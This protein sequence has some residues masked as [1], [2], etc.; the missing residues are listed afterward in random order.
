MAGDR[1]GQG[2]LAGAVRAHDG[3]GLPFADGQVHATQDLPVN[4][5]AL[6][7][8]DVQVADLEGGHYDSFSTAT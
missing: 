6:F 3:V 4:A 2:G 5:D 7:H 1:V 8:A